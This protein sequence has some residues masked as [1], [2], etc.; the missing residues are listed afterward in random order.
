MVNTA[1]GTKA[2]TPSPS[3]PPIKICLLVSRVINVTVQ[4]TEQ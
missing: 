2:A 1:Q 3:L 4:I